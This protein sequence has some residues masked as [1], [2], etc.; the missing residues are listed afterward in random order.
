MLFFAA[1]VLLQPDQ[2][3]SLDARGPAAANIAELWWIMFA[4]GTAV[5]L[6]VIALMFFGLFARHEEAANEERHGQRWILIGGVLMPSVVLAIV[7]GFTIRSSALTANDVSSS[8]LTIEVIGRRWWWEV[9]YPEQAVITANEIHIP[10][11]IPVEML[12]RSGDVIHSFWVPQL[13]GKMD[14]IPGRDNRLILQADEPG[15][16]RGE[17]AEYCGLQHAKM[18]FM[19]I[20]QDPQDFEQWTID[21]SQATSS[22]TDESIRYGQEVFISAGCVYCH[23][24]R[25]LDAGDVDR[26]TTDLGPDLTHLA[27]RTTIAAG[28]LDNNRGNLS[29]WIA[30]PHGIKPGVL[31]PATP[32]SGEELQ[33]LLTYLQT[34]R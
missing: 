24:I 20:A 1:N 2:P 13:H 5:F 23:T 11:G 15:I 26:S 9:N 30:D 31:M 6:L 19:V 17:C 21:Q 7:F 25:G 12:L 14:L 8:T 18:Q 16:Y 34:L 29:G 3:S 32:L 28:I 22:P 33:A 4:L 10:V 27:S